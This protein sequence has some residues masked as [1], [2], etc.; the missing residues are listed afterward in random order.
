MGRTMG[1]RMTGTSFIGTVRCD[2]GGTFGSK[3]FKTRLLLGS[4]PR[5]RAV[6]LLRSR[7]SVDGLRSIE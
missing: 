5:P 3:K 1:G 7:A 2:A 4:F 6:V